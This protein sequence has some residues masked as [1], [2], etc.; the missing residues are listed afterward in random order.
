MIAGLAIATGIPPR[1][2]LAESPEMVAT[3]VAVIND[4]RR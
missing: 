1:A 4:R 2:L 3:L